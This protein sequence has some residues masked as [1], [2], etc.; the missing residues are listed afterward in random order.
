M[1]YTHLSALVDNHFRALVIAEEDVEVDD[2]QVHGHL[3]RPWIGSRRSQVSSAA[4]AC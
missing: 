3:S 2:G 1:K 4:D